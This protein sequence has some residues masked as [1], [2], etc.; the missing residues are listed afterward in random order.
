MQNENSF[1]LIMERYPGLKNKI[2]WMKMGSFPTPVQKLTG[3]EKELG[4]QGVYIKR[5]DLTDINSGNAGYGGNK[6]R[7]FEFMLADAIAKNR[8]K[9]ITAGG[10]GTNH[11][12]AQSVFCDR[13]T[14]S[15]KYNL[16]SVVFC[17]D[18]PLTDHCRYNLKLDQYY[19]TELHYTGGIVKTIFSMLFYYIRHKGSYVVMPGASTPLGTVGFTNAI[20]ELKQQ[21]DAGKIPEP[22]YIFVAC[23]STGTAAGITLGCELA[24]LKTKIFAVAVS[25]LLVTNK[26]AV[27]SLALKCAKLLKKADPSIPDITKQQLNERLTV[28]EDFFGGLYG[29]PTE[30]GKEAIELIEKTDKIKLDLTY[31]GKT[32]SALLAFIRERKSELSGKTILFWNTLNSIDHQKEADS[33]DWHSLPPRFHRFFDETVKMEDRFVKARKN[34]NEIT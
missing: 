1:P 34:P 22:D 8:T 19:G 32:F 20:F 18:Q 6:I 5:D 23:G 13:L 4:F 9:L 26:K 15:G 2:P 28:L 21:I 12:L 10:I 16:K 30:E 17:F 27:V 29:L 3:L 25:M 14:K 24:G 31:T 33:V 7:K 11:G